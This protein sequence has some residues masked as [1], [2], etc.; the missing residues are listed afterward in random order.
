LLTRPAGQ[1]DRLATVLKA[2]GFE[3][4]CLPMLE[5]SAVTELAQ[6]ETVK[7]RIQQ[8]ADCDLAIFISSNAV[9][10]TAAFI[11]QSA[12]RWPPQL[13]CLGIGAATNQAIIDQAW[14][15]A[16]SDSEQANDAVGKQTSEAL[17]E[18]PALSEVEDKR[19]TIFRGVGGR[20]FLAE[21]LR[22][23]GALVEYCESYARHYPKYD[24]ATLLAALDLTDNKVNAIIFA[25]GE[26]LDN[27]YQ[28]LQDHALTAKLMSVPVIVPSQRV[29][30][31]AS[32]YGFKNIITAKNASAVGFVQ[33]LKE[34]FS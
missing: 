13:R 4:F 10:Y 19:I 5:L 17:L 9:N 12:L 20:E 28:H 30:T 8:L 1:A 11:S 31:L 25:S 34:T 32:D 22:S 24:K 33:A 23:R 7:S 15:L 21:E 26:T 2:D 18:S 14:R 29:Q 6:V 16:V 3:P 27:F